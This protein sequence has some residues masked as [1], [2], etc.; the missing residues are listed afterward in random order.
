MLSA[1]DAFRSQSVHTQTLTT[2]TDGQCV[3]RDGETHQNHADSS[4][5][6]EGAASLH[7][8]S[9]TPSALQGT[10]FVK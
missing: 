10:A 1:S 3:E 7:T 6:L 8:A 4:W 9:L 5:G 2:A